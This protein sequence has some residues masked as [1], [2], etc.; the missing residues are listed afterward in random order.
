M[1]GM[2]GSAWWVE[3]SAR[4]HLSP[5]GGYPFEAKTS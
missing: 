4:G 1:V 2:V 3:P 5:I